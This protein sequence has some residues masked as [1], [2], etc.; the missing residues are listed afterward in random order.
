MRPVVG[1]KRP[2]GDAVFQSEGRAPFIGTMGSSF[3]SVSR[4]V[5][6]VAFALGCAAAPGDV[7]VVVDAAQFDAVDALDQQWEAVGVDVGKLTVTTEGE[8]VRV[9]VSH[10]HA[11]LATLCPDPHRVPGASIPL[12]C[13]IRNEDESARVIYIASDA[14]DPMGLLRHEMGHLIRGAHGKA[15]L[16]ER[17]GCSPVDAAL[18]EIVAPHVMC[19]HEGAHVL[20][21]LDGAFVMRRAL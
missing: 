12:G 18:G 14:P 11:E 9:D 16:D 17:A 6:G 21:E 13:V 20:D 4:W 15:H 10:P 3:R 5:L 19:P 8:G 1:Q 2:R 7:T